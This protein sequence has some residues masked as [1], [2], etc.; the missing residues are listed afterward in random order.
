MTST[1]HTHAPAQTRS[2]ARNPV[3]V[4]VLAALGLPEDADAA[5][6]LSAVAELKAAV[7]ERTGLEPQHLDDFRDMASVNVE[8]ERRKHEIAAE[9]RKRQDEERRERLLA[10]A[11]AEGRIK[12]D[13]TDALRA[14]YSISPEAVKD[15]LLSVPGPD[16]RRDVREIINAAG[17]VVDA[18]S[19]SDWLH[20]R[21]LAILAERRIVEPT[22]EEYA[23]ALEAARSVQEPKDGSRTWTS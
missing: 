10:V 22:E 2:E 1:E 3:S 17:E 14:L 18:R 21:A 15:L 9:E 4:D 5:S 11:V 19:D 7:E 16:P 13:Q 12:E 6:L 8:Y 20:C 23:E